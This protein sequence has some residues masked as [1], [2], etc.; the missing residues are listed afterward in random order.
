VLVLTLLNVVEYNCYLLE[1]NSQKLCRY[2]FCYDCDSWHYV[3]NSWRALWVNFDN[4]V[5]QQQ[6]TVYSQFTS[7]NSKK[8][9][10]VIIKNLP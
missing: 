5:Y 6:K 4:I 8:Y 9:K 3:V 2:L 7:Y 1:L 10:K